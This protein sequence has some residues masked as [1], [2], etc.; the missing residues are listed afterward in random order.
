MDK[1]E[2]I[3]IFD[4]LCGWCYGFDP[5]MMRLE[6][7]YADE[8][9]FVVFSGGMLVGE[10]ARPIAEMRGY[11]KSVLPT[12]AERTGIE[13][14]D[15]FLTG[16]LEDDTYINDSL[17]PSMALNAFKELKPEGALAYA[18]DLQFAHFVEGKS[19]N[20]PATFVA[21]AESNGVGAE[22]FMERY[23]DPECRGRTEAEFELW[24][25]L[26]V[27]GYPTLILAG[28]E[29]MRGVSRGFRTFEEL[30][31]LLEKMLAEESAGDES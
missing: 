26:G 24:R 23:Q 6:R 5:V 1:P 16:I 19:L 31:P 4:P 7:N 12:L 29:G 20:D 11:I 14:G 15:A 18:H 8:V 30:A 22:A 27:S 25:G 3:Y 10:A 28:R 9:D 2:L 13:V 21:V 17:P